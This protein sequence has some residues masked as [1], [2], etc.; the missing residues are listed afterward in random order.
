MNI[1][2]K[3]TL[4]GLGA[5]CALTLSLGV[6]FL[7]NDHGF[8]N[9]AESDNI[10]KN[11]FGEHM[12]DADNKEYTLAKKF[13]QALEQ[14]NNDG[15]FLDGVVDYPLTGIVTSDQ[16]KGWVENGNLEVPK[17]FSAARDTFLTDHPEIFYIDFYKLTISVAKSGNEYVGFINSGKEANLFYDNGGMTT[18]DAVN[19]AIAKYNERIDYFVNDANAAADDNVYTERDVFLARHVSKALGA[20]IRYDS[21]AYDNRNDPDAQASAHIN[22]AYGGLVV[23]TAV[24]GGYSRSYKVIMDKLGIP[25]ITVNGYSKEKYNI[26]NPDQNVYHM[27]NYVYLAKPTSTA[28]ANAVSG[29]AYADTVAGDWYS[30]DVTWKKPVLSAAADAATHLNDGVISSGGYEL[31]YPMLASHNYGSTLEEFGLSASLDYVEVTG[32][33]DDYGKPLMHTYVTLSYNGKSAKKLLEED[34]LH[35]AYRAADY[36]SDTGITWT[37]WN[38]VER[39]RQFMGLDVNEDIR[40]SDDGHETRFI[41]PPTVYFIQFAVFEDEPDVKAPPAWGSEVYYRYSEEKLN[42]INALET[43]EV[44]VNQTYGTYTPAPY[45]QSSTP[46]HQVEQVISDSM[47]DPKSDKVIMAENK[48]IIYELTYDEPL[49]ILDTSKPIGIDFISDHPNARE[50]ARFYPFEGENGEQVYVELVQRPRNSIDSTLVYNTLRFKFAPSLMYEHNR[51]GYFITF[52]NVGSAKEVTRIVDG[53]EVIETSNKLPNS[54]YYSFGR[55][56]MACPARFN[57]DGRL[58]VE[59]CA[60]P[61]LVSNT[62][63]S[64]M[65]FRDENNESTFSENERSQMMLVAE[66]ADTSTVNTMLDEITDHDDIN[67]TKN[68]IK[69]SETY[70]I[71]LQICGKYPKIPDG[72]YVKIALGFPEGYGPDDEGVTFKLFHRKHMDGDNYII[73]E[74][75][76]VVTRFGIVATVTSFSPYM[77]AVVDADKATDKTVYASIESKG[78]TL[79]KDDGKIISLKEGESYTYTFTPNDGYQI[80][81]V[82]LNG[83]EVKDKLVDDKLTLSYDE[84]KSSNEVVVQYIAEAAAERI[85][86]K[87]ADGKI[88]EDVAVNATQFVVSLPSNNVQPDNHTVIIVIAVV[89]AVLVVASAVAIVLIVRKKKSK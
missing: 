6:G 59:C 73:E 18:V 38:S 48:A 67:V 83:K 36:R 66:K 12:L 11:Y 30:V 14:L 58:W 35:I 71:S 23:G 39:S 47:R 65:D 69:T 57:Y 52:T 85:Q 64:A 2:K 61:T 19:D 46:T 24:C 79:T 51:E 55:L 44:Q 70:D 13:Y 16:L 84:L 34:G 63:L 86:T 89:C 32:E 49:H 56:Y 26:S 8:V 60:Q 3:F 45:I 80:Y 29:V 42:T 82:L 22:T 88:T 21:T 74:V 75:P 4:A 53:K 81:S 17:A 77:V 15:E 41:E 43:S 40:W 62:D 54:A 72:S 1:T 50:Y 27:W 68:D 87:I 31:K 76:C 28:T 9:A 37:P 78:G 25:C 33:T 7:A 20:A 10:A 5:A